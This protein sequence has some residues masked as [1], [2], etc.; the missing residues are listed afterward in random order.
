MSP[1]R[2][3]RSRD[4]SKRVDQRREA[5][6]MSVDHQDSTRQAVRRRLTHLRLNQTDLATRAGVSRATVNAFLTGA[7]WPSA[8]T[9][10]RIEEALGWPPGA[11]EEQATEPEPDR[12][13]TKNTAAD[14]VTILDQEVMMSLTPL[15]RA[16]VNAAG[17]AAALKR[18]REILGQNG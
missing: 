5:V 4:L 8:E 10:G 18:L 16:E 9:L 1:E 2:A 15:Q 14:F 17:T 3:R 12:P 6:D 13:A 7:T 11:I